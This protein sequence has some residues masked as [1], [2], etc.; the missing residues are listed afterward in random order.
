MPEMSGIDLLVEIRQSCPDT[1]IIVIT[2]YADK[3]IAIKALSLGACDFLEKPMAIDLLHHVV[4]RA[5]DTQ[6]TE[7]EHRQTL[8]EFGKK[9]Q[10][11]LETIEALSVLMKNIDRAKQE[12]GKMIVMQFRSLLVPIIENL[13]NERDA[14]VYKSQLAMLSN[15]I[16]NLTVDLS[17]GQQTNSSSLALLS[18]RELQI[19]L[20][21]KNYMTNEEIAARLHI[22]PET[23][24]THRRNIRKKL[25]MKG[26]KARLNV[27]LLALQGNALGVD[28]SRQIDTA[29]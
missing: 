2:G 28:I 19:A 11:L 4:K 6:R 13:Q 22:S 27:H 16:E 14:A 18:I 23:V 17:I 21:I 7:I 25:G 3:D 15:Y 1:K 29:V 20:M 9:S 5:L 26:T 10:E 24:R 8:A 12:M